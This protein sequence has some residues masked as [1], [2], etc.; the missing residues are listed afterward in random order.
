MIMSV[1]IV[2]KDTLKAS[3]KIENIDLVPLRVYLCDFE[4]NTNSLVGNDLSITIF[5]HSVISPYA[6]FFTCLNITKVNK[7]EM[8]KL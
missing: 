3:T 8:F 5:R 4:K 1:L 6:P 2:L 7:W